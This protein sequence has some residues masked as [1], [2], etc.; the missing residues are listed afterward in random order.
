MR[1]EQ[2][3]VEAFHAKYGEDIGETPR[4]GEPEYAERRA[5]LMKEESEE[6]EQAAYAGDLTGIA[7]AIADQ[8]YI[9]LGTAVYHGI[10]IQ[11]IFEEVHRSNM[12]KD[13]NPSTFKKA[14][15]G[16]A[17]EPPRIAELL[18]IQTTG[19][20]GVTTEGS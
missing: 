14:V 17:Y 5:K 8:L 15:K 16:P 6:Y 12:T 2:E 13:Y 20:A 11:P 9:L 4:V 10:D 7:D 18:L 19:L 3:K 1:V